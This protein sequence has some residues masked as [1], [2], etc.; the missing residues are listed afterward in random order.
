MRGFVKT[1]VVFFF[2]LIDRLRRGG[3]RDYLP[4]VLMYHSVEESE[5]KY[6]VTPDDF[7][8][9]IE[10]LVEHYTV[11]PLSDIVAFLQGEKTLPLNAIAITIDD[12]YEDTYTTVFPLLKKHHI[13]A[14]VFLTTNLEKKEKL[15]MLPR[16]T[17]EQ[18]KE[19]HDSGLVT[20]EV[21]GRE[22]HNLKAL[23]DDA[24][25]VE[26]LGCRDDIR[27]HLGYTPRYIAY[28]SGHKDER[29]LSFVRNN[30]FVGGFSI[31]EGHVSLDDGL[32]AIRRTQ[33]D[34]TMGLRLFTMRLTGA[35]DLNRRFV[36][37]IR[38]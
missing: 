23:A 12:G 37:W 27:E 9:Q 30:G 35:I 18:C 10:H 31:N 8:W 33:V 22:H 13:P 26:V 29:V 34:G 5:W 4:T 38:R 16:I 15:G 20:F 21:H 25:A 24:L 36:D 6:S 1:T 14:T 2:Y 11:V 32:F 7:R 3:V 17:W 28:A 19:M